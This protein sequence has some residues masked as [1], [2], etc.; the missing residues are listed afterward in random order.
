MDDD[1][2]TIQ[3]VLAGDIDTF[4][5]LVERHQGPL[6]ALVGNLV[7]DAADRDDIA[8][9]TFLAAYLHLGSYDPQKA[10]FSTW[11]LTIARNKCINA[12]TQRR[13]LA[14]E[15]LPPRVDRRGP[16]DRLLEREFF[17]QL[18]QALAALPFEQKTAFV[19][20]EIEGLS[21]EEI[22]QIEDVPLG[23]VKSRISRAKEK[24]RSLFSCLPETR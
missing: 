14:M 8:Q 3:R 20:S 5:V 4:R 17:T 11:L 1:L 7:R 6:F 10:K 21:H 23:T 12:M 9:E 13:P 15:A 18:D 22:C 19:L 24:L 2:Q 16:A